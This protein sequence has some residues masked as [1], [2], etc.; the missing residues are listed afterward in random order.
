[1]EVRFWRTKRGDEVDFILLKN[2]KPFAIEC[3]SNLKNA[4]IPAGIKKFL[5]HYPSTEGAIVFNDNIDETLNYSNRI[6]QFQSW[7]RADN[8]HYLQNVL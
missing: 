7:T 2:R 3:K 6:V 4:D 1:M 5:D 8:I